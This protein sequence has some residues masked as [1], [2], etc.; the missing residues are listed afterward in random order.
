MCGGGNG[1]KVDEQ[2]QYV[3]KIFFFKFGI[4]LWFSSITVTA[5]LCDVLDSIITCARVT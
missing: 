4:A 3:L 5:C 2:S 1:E